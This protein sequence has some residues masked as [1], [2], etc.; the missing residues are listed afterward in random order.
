MKIEAGWLDLPETQ[1][2]FAAL[3]HGGHRALA[4][5]GCVRNTL[6]GVAVADVDIASDAR[7]ERVVEL[8]GAAGFRVVPTGIEHGTVTVVANHRPYEVTT[9]RRDVET[10][11]RRARVAFSDDVAEDARRRDFTMNALY[12]EADG[13]VVDPLGGLEDLQRRHV[14]FVGDPRARIGEDY[15]RI[16]RFFRFH[17][18]YGD[19]AGGLDREGLAGCAALADGLDH[20]SNER[21]GHE[22]MRLLAAPDPAPSVAAMEVTGVLRHVLPGATAELLPRLVAVETALGASPDALRRLAALG[23]E[24][25]GPHLRLSRSAARRLLLLRDLIGAE[26]GTAELAWRHGSQNAIDAELLRAAAFCAPLP[27]TLARD[28]EAGAAAKF[29]IS[30]R[31]LMPASRGPAVGQKLKELE[32]RWIASDFTLNR[33]Q[34][35]SQG[36]EEG[37]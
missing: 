10:D 4:V 34:L 20:L 17:A 8:V 27:A 7:P 6:L 31:D 3:R 18:W 36:T 22:T 1:A 32:A 16:L 35:L 2:I 19:P 28:A 26:A 29:P 25:P 33:D 30:A 37:G 11:G 13:R 21:I 5:G 23:G 12:S 9:F 15:L 14:R 24:A